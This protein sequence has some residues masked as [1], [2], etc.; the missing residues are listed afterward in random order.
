VLISNMLEQEWT[1]PLRTPRVPKRR[2]W[3]THGGTA[4]GRGVGWV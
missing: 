2:G 3:D 4:L 1:A